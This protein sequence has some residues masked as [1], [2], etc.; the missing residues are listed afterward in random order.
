MNTHHFHDKLFKQV[1]SDPEHA[2]SFFRGCL[3][4]R[5]LDVLDINSLIRIDG[6]FFDKE[7]VESRTD[8]LFKVNTKDGSV[9]YIYVLLEHKS[10]PDHSTP[11]QILNYMVRIWRKHEKENRTSILPH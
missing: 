6:T 11:L 10:Y 8:I 2:A 7:F 1:F 4:S 5:T 3:P 9:N